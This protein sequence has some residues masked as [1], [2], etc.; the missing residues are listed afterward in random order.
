M[1]LQTIIDAARALG[2]VLGAV[3]A[4]VE[5]VD[6]AISTLSEPDQAKAKAALEELRAENDALHDR[7]QTKLAAAAAQE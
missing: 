1:N 7:L 6:N 3:P 4:I 5:L 2:P